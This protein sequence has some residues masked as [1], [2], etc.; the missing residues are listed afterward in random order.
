MAELGDHGDAGGQVLK[1]DDQADRRF[2]GRDELERQL[3]DDAERALGADHQVQEVIA[4]AGLGDRGAEVGD[5]A[6]GQDHGH[7][8]HIVPRGPVLHAPHAAGV[9][10]DVAAQGGQLL[11]RIRG[12]ET[13]MG[14]GVLRQLLEENTGLDG[15]GVVVQVIAQDLVHFGG[16]DDHAAHHGHT[17]T[18]Q[19]CARTAGGDG[20]VVFI[21]QLHHGGNFLRGQGI[22]RRLRHAGAIDGH[23]VPAVVGVHVVPEIDPSGGDFFQ[24]FYD[25]FGHR[26]IAS[27]THNPPFVV[28]LSFLFE[29]A[30]GSRR[31]KPA[32]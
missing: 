3:C 11:P 32:R 29:T 21:A 8:L 24:L 15:H 17:A 4:G 22:H 19:P 10:G 16:G 9:G 12:I 28:F 23:F 13:F 14:Q 18:H 5:L 30:G 6:G 1:G 31:L 7:G 27:H 20:D 25:L 26:L 2:R